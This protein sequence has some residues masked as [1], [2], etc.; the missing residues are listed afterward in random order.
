M[1][2]RP[3]AIVFGVLALSLTSR[4]AD[5]IAVM[6]LDGES[7]GTY[8]DW[9]RV[10]PVLK[11]ILDET[12]LFAVTVVTAPSARGELANFKPDFTKFRVMVMNYDAPDERW[13]AS[14]KTTFEQYVRTGGGIVAVQAADNAFAGWRAFNEMVG[15]A[16]QSTPVQVGTTATDWWRTPRRVGPGATVGVCP[17]R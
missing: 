10:T 2:M 5:P 9:Q 4:A 13:P 15:A 11:K 16:A 1:R 8:H 17:S 3:L 6:L 12:K 7:G 14:L